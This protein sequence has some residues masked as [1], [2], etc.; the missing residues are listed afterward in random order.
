[1]QAKS[2][3]ALTILYIFGYCNTSAMI[4]YQEIYSDNADSLL[5]EV[6]PK[7]SVSVLIQPILQNVKTNSG[8]AN[9]V[10]GLV[11]L[12]SNVRYA[13]KES[14]RAWIRAI[15]EKFTGISFSL[16]VCRESHAWSPPT[17]SSH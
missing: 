7:G 16:F 17:K 12:V 8:P 14:D 4:Y 9:E 5:W 13:Y 1:M 2:L 10:L 15:A 6:L 3:A 11:V